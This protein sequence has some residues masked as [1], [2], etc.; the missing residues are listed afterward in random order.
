MQEILGKVAGVVRRECG[1]LRSFGKELRGYAED[2][3]VHRS[4]GEE[5]RGYVRRDARLHGA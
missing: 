4:L 2:A 3:K 1:I 5:L